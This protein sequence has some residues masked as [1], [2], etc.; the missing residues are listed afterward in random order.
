M[1]E[2]LNLKHLN[3]PYESEIQ[4]AIQRVVASGWYLLGDELRNFEDAF[5]TYCGTQHAIGVSNGLDALTLTLLAWKELGKLSAGD[6]VLVPA[7]SYIASIL[8]VCEAGL[9]PILVEPD[10]ASFNMADHNLEPHLSHKTKAIL[11]VHL[12]GRL[13][14]MEALNVFAEKHDLLVLEDAAQAHGAELNGKRAGNWGDAGAFSFYPGKNLGALGDA[15]AITTNDQ[16]LYD[17]LSALR[18]YGSKEK[19]HH[20]YRGRN[21]RMDEIQAA[22]LSVK[23]SQLDAANKRR[24]EIAKAYNCMIDTPDITLPAIPSAEK[25]HVWH[26]YVV[27]SAARASF[28]KHLESM[29]IQSAVHYPIP[30]H[31]QPAFEQTLGGSFPVTESIHKEV[32]SLPLNP[33]LHDNDIK[34]IAEACNTFSPM[35]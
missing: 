34:L 18:N 20:S 19:Y 29:N 26:L 1:I 25:S 30:P 21:N 27:R 16:E 13:C 33:T 15:G 12:Y 11:P 35:Q 4:T 2:F 7:N 8:A 14:N 32:V 9:T 24:Q 23:L 28:Q 31:K 22:V 6:E 5:A 17:C 3:A 10:D